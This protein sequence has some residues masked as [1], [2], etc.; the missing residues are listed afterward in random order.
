MAK[1]MDA[2][3]R[4]R[5]SRC[6]LAEDQVHQD[7]RR[8]SRRR[9]TCTATSWATWPGASGSCSG[10]V[11]PEG[12]LLDERGEF[13][14]ECRRCRGTR[15]EPFGSC[16]AIGSGVRRSVIEVSTCGT[17]QEG[18]ALVPATMLGSGRTRLPEECT[19]DQFQ[20]YS[21]RAVLS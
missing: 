2:P 10:E 9:A 1:R 17:Q 21:R 19:W 12:P 13:F 14:L 16:S 7:L 11:A 18:G 5:A 8:G 3:V 4:S 15:L 6:P 20:A